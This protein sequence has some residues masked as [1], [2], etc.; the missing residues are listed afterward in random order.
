MLYILYI[1]A[2]FPSISFISSTIWQTLARLNFQLQ[3]LWRE[4]LILNRFAKSV[5]LFL[6]NMEAGQNSVFE[7][8]VLPCSKIVSVH[9]CVFS[10]K[11]TV[12]PFSLYFL[13][14]SYLCLFCFQI[15]NTTRKISHTII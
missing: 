13:A 1:L 2:C 8:K 6:T 10:F 9:C 4:F 5:F 15:R 7:H 14:G 11:G 3:G 12:L